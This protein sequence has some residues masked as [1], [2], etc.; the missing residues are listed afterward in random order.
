MQK[1]P[2]HFLR[3]PQ[4]PIID[5]LR[6]EEALLRLDH[7]NWCI[8]NEGSPP[9][10]VLGISGKVELMVN[11]SRY[12]QNPVPLIQRFSGGGT[13]FIDEDTLFVT[14]LLNGPEVNVPSYPDRVFQWSEHFYR[15]IFGHLPFS[16][17]ENDYVCHD[18]K[19][20]GNAQYMRHQRWLHHTS[21]LWDFQQESMDYL[22]MPPK[23][24]LYRSD[25]K[26]QDFLCRL[27]DFFIDKAE[28]E[29]KLLERLNKEFDMKES[30]LKNAM[31]LMDLPHRRATVEIRHN[32]LIAP[33]LVANNKG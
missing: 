27:K 29:G 4:W 6:L 16:L 30:C 3:L 12:E 32:A 7:R 8:F 28:V 25:R 22:K 10:I 15:P 20:G 14:F 31:A 24:P 11:P 18:R 5:Q 1:P 26:H 17:R 19:F 23:R 21:L 33:N 2:L 9:A 13:V